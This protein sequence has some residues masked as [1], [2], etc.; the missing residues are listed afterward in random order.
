MQRNNLAQ[1][2]P[3]TAA[4]P[5]RSMLSA[6]K[7]GAIVRPVRVV[8]YGPEGIGKS[9]FAANAPSP[10]FLGAEEGTSQLDVARLPEPKCWQDVL[11]AIDE[12]STES[13]D[14][15]T[16][17]LDTLDWLE[18]LCWAE[19]CRTGGKETIEDFGF[20]KGYVAALDLWRVLLA[21]IDQMR[22]AK[23]LHVV[24]LAHTWIRPFNNPVGD[25]FDRYELKL[26]TKSSGL[27][28]EW[29]DALLFSQYETFTKK[30]DGGKVRAVSTG[31]RVVHTTRNAAWDAKT[32]YPLPE[33]IALDWGEFWGAVERGE[34]DSPERLTAAIESMLDAVPADTRKRVEAS[35]AKA[36]G[37]AVELSR[38]A[39][40]LSAIVNNQEQQS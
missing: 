32:R 22:N 10:I 14:F 13:H 4:K 17:V 23:G 9:T 15:K 11:D 24:A 20:G 7:R 26:H 1:V 39:N 2:Q 19:V 37:N 6:V 3:A 8:L 38:I 5:K 31:A 27:W 33:T 30:L 29:C 28:K 40:R 35:V 16:L 25:N 21:R 34:P 36:A 12:L 18:P